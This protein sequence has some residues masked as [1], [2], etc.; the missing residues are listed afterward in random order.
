VIEG[1][2]VCSRPVFVLTNPLCPV[3]D[4]RGG[5]ENE[6]PAKDAEKQEAESGQPCSGSYGSSS[7]GETQDAE[8]QMAKLNE[9]E[10]DAID[11]DRFDY[12]PKNRS[13]TAELSEIR[14]VRFLQPLF[15]DATDV[16]FAIRSKRTGRVERFYLY[17]EDWNG[18]DVAGWRFRSVDRSLDVEVLVIND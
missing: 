1:G 4:R 8:R 17:K 15:T 18:D 9:R 13:F 5:D 14:P 2:T 7:N 16:G 10:V 3:T 12:D 11:S 6:T